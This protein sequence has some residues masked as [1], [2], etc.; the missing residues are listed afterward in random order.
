[1]HPLLDGLEELHGF[2]VGTIMGGVSHGEP[3]SSDVRVVARAAPASLSETPEQVAGNI[4]T[5]AKRTGSASVRTNLASCARASPPEKL[6]AKSSTT[7][8]I[9]PVAEHIFFSRPDL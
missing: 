3:R 6:N 5:V 4:R 1:M 8:R 7:A 9:L 2:T